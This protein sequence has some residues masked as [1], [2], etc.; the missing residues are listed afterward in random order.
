MWFFQ[1][2]DKTTLVY[3]NYRFEYFQGDIEF[4]KRFHPTYSVF[5][6]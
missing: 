3:Y 1:Y 2:D 6:V 5:E 4:F